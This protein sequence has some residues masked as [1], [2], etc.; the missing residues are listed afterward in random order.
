MN[1]FQRYNDVKNGKMTG[2]QFLQEA[3]WDPI[4][5]KHITNFD[6]FESAVNTFK[7]KG[8]LFESTEAKPKTFSA[9]EWIKENT[10]AFS[11]F[12]K[13]DVDD[14]QVNLFE[15]EKGWRYELKLSG[16]CD[17]EAV[18]KAKAKAVKNLEKD[19]I[20]YTK[21]EM[22]ELA[23]DD[24]NTGTVDVSKGQNKVDDKNSAKP[25]KVK[26]VDSDAKAKEYL[27]KSE[28][29]GKAPKEIT[30]NEGLELSSGLVGQIEKVKNFLSKLG[31]DRKSK[32]KYKEALERLEMVL[33][34]DS[35]KIV[36]TLKNTI[37][38][39]SPDFPN[40]KSGEDFRTR[41]NDIYTVYESLK[42]A[43]E[44]NV[45]DEN[46][47][48]A[49]IFNPI[50]ESLREY[51]KFLRDSA[52]SNTY[53]YLKEGQE[54]LNEVG[55]ASL[56][57]KA[58]GI[59]LGAS[60][61][62]ED[63]QK[64]IEKVG[65]G[66]FEKGL[67]VVKNVF[68]GNGAGTPDQ[69]A[70]A[71]KDLIDQGISS[72]A[73]LADLFD[74]AKGTFGSAKGGNKIFSILDPNASI[75]ALKGAA[76][77]T[78]KA[79]ADTTKAVADTA[80]S[81]GSE[82]VNITKDL[83]SNLLGP[84]GVGIGIA[85][86]FAAADLKK[87]KDSRYADLTKL[88]NEL[89]PV[90]IKPKVIKPEDQEGAASDKEVEKAAKQL[91]FKEPIQIGQSKGNE[92]GPNDISKPIE[93]S[94]ELPADFKMPE[95]PADKKEPKKDAPKNKAPKMSAKPGK[96]APVDDTE[97]DEPEAPKAKATKKPAASKASAADKADPINAKEK[98]AETPKEAPAK[99]AAAKKSVKAVPFTKDTYKDK[100]EAKIITMKINSSAGD[101][102]G[103]D[104]KSVK[105]AVSS[106]VYD[107]YKADKVSGGGAL[108]KAL[109][110]ITTKVKSKSKVMTVDLSDMEP[111]GISKVSRGE[112][113]ITKAGKLKEGGYQEE[114]IMEIMFEASEL[115]NLTK[116]HTNDKNPLVSEGDCGCEDPKNKVPGGLGD[117]LSAADVD[118]DELAMGL[119]IEGEHTEDPEI[120]M[121]IAL[122]HLAEDPQYYS[123][124]KESGLEEA[125]VVKPKRP[126][127]AD[128]PFY[129]VQNERDIIA[130]F[131]TEDEATNFTSS[132]PEE[133]LSVKTKNGL[134][135][136]PTKPKYNN[137]ENWK[138]IDINKS[139]WDY[140][141][142]EARERLTEV[143]RG[144]ARRSLQEFT[145]MPQPQGPDVDRKH[146][147]NLLSGIDW[148]AVG[149]P[150]EIDNGYRT[151]INQQKI[152]DIKE[153]INRM[154]QEGIDLY[155]EYAPE[156]CKW[157]EKDELFNMQEESEN[158]I[159]Q[160]LKDM[161]DLDP[162][163]LAKQ[164]IEKGF[165]EHSVK[166]KAAA[167]IL[168]HAIKEGEKDPEVK[169]AFMML[170]D[171]LKKK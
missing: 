114:D 77:D 42:A 161:E 28:E 74:K 53:K 47:L 38:K 154:G 39:A 93:L 102:P 61:T 159:R 126:Y 13:G 141:L 107:K 63:L 9:T 168:G 54:Q 67:N 70:D 44:T 86:L 91:G 110:L 2:D 87:K 71:L 37:E 55:M 80:S 24:K 133:K 84:L 127:R 92:T 18:S 19:P 8:L 128:W 170:S 96:S 166:N 50:V 106:K 152:N 156:G 116:S 99:K 111:T 36:N 129:V 26:E 136:M 94:P 169:K 4:L 31:P 137:P 52:L 112:I 123:K 22:G 16:K 171:K 118:A 72:G 62:A 103:E 75:E 56:L 34:K 40:Q 155:N 79:V 163:D 20:H 51:V 6:T 117:K 124:M 95:K 143:L 58:T 151:S 1:L 69:Q 27:K 11:T 160:D 165:P 121:E 90:N 14:S 83:D 97:E 150:D 142:K 113:K 3:K 153:L 105:F 109:A 7:N 82:V 100:P 33:E 30:L 15:F 57:Q 119:T 120:A 132:K 138:D 35:E 139:M 41:L 78:A 85:L 32:P 12:K 73:T 122:D 48:P 115:D 108:K 134:A 146:L 157:G 5:S 66:D 59:N 88:L 149:E 45:K 167:M 98:E 147:K 60:S 131:D 125:G 144:I 158:M 21:L 130:G 148:P 135:A 140:N 43:T 49:E 164:V 10:Q 17:E 76:S 23:P 162:K 46:H 104:F 64:A 68:K 29:K 25:V 65:A 89:K 81:V 101:D 145:F